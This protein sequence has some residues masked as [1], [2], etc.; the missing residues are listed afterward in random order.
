M[1]S[2]E[3]QNELNFTRKRNTLHQPTKHLSWAQ[4]LLHPVARGHILE[5]FVHFKRHV[6]VLHRDAR[7]LL[8]VEYRSRP[9]SVWLCSSGVADRVRGDE[10]RSGCVGSGE[11][12]AKQWP[13]L[14]AGRVSQRSF[15][16]RQARNRL[17]VCALNIQ[18]S[19]NISASFTGYL[20]S[21]ADF[22]APAADN[23]VSKA[24]RA[25]SLSDGQLRKW[26]PGFALSAALHA[27]AATKQKSDVM[28][29]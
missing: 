16:S 15:R 9:I 5:I 20:F 8:A 3:Q 23:A 18:Q 26:P 7:M 28:V 6:L 21:C 24:A 14:H 19:F 2:S 25:P 22:S 1:P 11:A 29:P 12:A 13:N 10:V 4:V 27:N 17:S